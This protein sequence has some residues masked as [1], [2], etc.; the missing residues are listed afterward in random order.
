MGNGGDTCLHMLLARRRQLRRSMARGRLRAK[1]CTQ[2]ILGFF[3]KHVHVRR[4][5]HPWMQGNSVR[6]GA[7]T[8]QSALAERFLRA[9]ARLSVVCLA[10]LCQRLFPLS[11]FFWFPLVFPF[12]LFVSVFRRLA[13]FWPGATA[14]LPWGWL[15]GRSAGPAGG[16]AGRQ[17]HW[18]T[19]VWPLRI[20]LLRWIAGLVVFLLH[21][22]CLTDM[23]DGLHVFVFPH[24]FGLANGPLPGTTLL[25]CSDP[26]RRSVRPKLLA[27]T[28]LTRR[29]PGLR[30]GK[31]IHA[32]MLALATFLGC[33]AILCTLPASREKCP[34]L[35]SMARR[36]HLGMPDRRQLLHGWSKRRTSLFVSCIFLWKGMF[37]DSRLPCLVALAIAG[38]FHS[39]CLSQVHVDSLE[40]KHLVLP[41]LAPPLQVLPCQMVS[42]KLWHFSG[43]FVQPSHEGPS[44]ELLTEQVE[45]ETMW[46]AVHS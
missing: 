32:H 9:I 24:C 23:G 4:Q 35:P 11:F 21:F 28:R 36:P 8:L 38:C 29:L 34:K 25:S 12:K 41:E 37:A 40:P 2:G 42:T 10:A 45:A 17:A 33:T 7:A 22:D 44:F 5:V 46:E 3:V 31:E 30:Q 6:L 1:R 16:G 43:S 18:A 13:E 39:P 27:E 26:D 19:L 14:L 20:F 15:G